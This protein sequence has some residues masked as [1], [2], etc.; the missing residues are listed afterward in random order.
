MNVLSSFPPE[1]YIDK[2]QAFLILEP[3][4][5]Y[6]NFVVFYSVVYEVD[7]FCW[8]LRL[9]NTKVVC[10]FTELMFITVLLNI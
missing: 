8:L 3:T 10:I 2:K 9:R 5:H 7:W 1:V 4:S 6:S